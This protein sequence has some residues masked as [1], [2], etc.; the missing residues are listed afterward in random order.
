MASSQIFQS[1]KERFV[2]IFIK[3]L[4]HSDVKKIRRIPTVSVLVRLCSVEML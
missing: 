3:V 2:L 4:L 1:Q